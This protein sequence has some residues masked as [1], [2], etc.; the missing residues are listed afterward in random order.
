MYVSVR[1]ATQLSEKDLNLHSLNLLWTLMNSSP[2][3][4]GFYLSSRAKFHQCTDSLAKTKNEKFTGQNSPNTLKT[5]NKA[6][7]SVSQVF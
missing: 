1:T 5:V 7:T 6:I 3:N 4:S 2:G